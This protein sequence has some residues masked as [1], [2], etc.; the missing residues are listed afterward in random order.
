MAVG[1][2]GGWY[3]G[4]STKE[5]NH[6]RDYHDVA[7][8]VEA[9]KN[10]EI[11]HLKERLAGLRAKKVEWRQLA[12][13][14]Q[15]A[16][17]ILTARLAKLQWSEKRRPF[18]LTFNEADGVYYRTAVS[19]T[20]EVVGRNGWVFKIDPNVRGIDQDSASDKIVRQRRR[21]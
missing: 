16:N 6:L 4:H 13:D 5:R 1:A 3:L 8:V 7:Q 18:I 11:N 20:E 12:K 19:D 10:A 14:R 2:G 21:R 9:E 15:E 17:D